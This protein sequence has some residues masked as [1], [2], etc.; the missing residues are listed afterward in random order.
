MRTNHLFHTRSLILGAIIIAAAVIVSSDSL[1]EKIE[2]IIRYAESIIY[3]YPVY[4]V[5][6][7]VAL[8]IVS[9]MLAFYSSAILVPIGVYA[10]GATECFILLWIGWILGGILS[11]YIGYNYGRSVAVKLIGNS[12]F[13]NF[14]NF[15]GQNAKFAHILLLQTALPSEIPGYL[16]GALRYHFPSYLMALAIAELPYAIGTVFLGANFL[17]R[18]SVTIILIGIFVIIASTWIYL[19]FKKVVHIENNT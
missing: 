10:W 12:R 13:T 9:A 8:A 17:Q 4:G 19:T 7:F 2:Y 1:Y 15:F 14:E 5:L 16:L 11:F 18:N 6:L 3:Q